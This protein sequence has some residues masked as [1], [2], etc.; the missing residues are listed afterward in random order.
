MTDLFVF[1]VKDVLTA[2]DD[3]EGLI[4]MGVGVEM[5]TWIVDCIGGCEATFIIK[6]HD[7]LSR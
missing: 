6:L 1:E 7:V 5:V 2:E 4:E 3:D